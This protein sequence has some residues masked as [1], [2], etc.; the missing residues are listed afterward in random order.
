MKQQNG[1]LIRSFTSLVHPR[2][3]ALFINLK[4]HFSSKSI[5][6]SISSDMTK[7]FHGKVESSKESSLELLRYSYI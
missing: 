7:A 1:P 5:G 2:P 3:I 4:C 6:F